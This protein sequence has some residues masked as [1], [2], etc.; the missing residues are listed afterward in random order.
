[1]E[2]AVDLNR[3]NDLDR[4]FRWLRRSALHCLGGRHQLGGCGRLTILKAW[5][6]D[7]LQRDRSPPD[8]SGASRGGAAAPPHPWTMV[9]RRKRL[10][11]S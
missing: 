7:R 8:E 2:R 3:A 9:M 5:R 6:F 10:V 4:Q 1:M 11:G